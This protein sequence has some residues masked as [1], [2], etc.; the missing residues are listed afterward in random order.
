MTDLWHYAFVH[1]ALLAGAIV[2]LLAGVVG[3][4]VVTRNMAFAVH[5]S[6]EVGF[7]GAAGAL[8]IGLPPQVG[9][10]GAALATAVAIGVLGVRV[11][12]RDAAIGTTLAFGLGLGALFLSLYTRYANEAFSLLFGT[13]L[14]ISAQDVV[15]TAAVAAAS[16]ATLAVVYRPLRFASV[17]PEVAMARGVPVR[18][19]SIVF[20]VILAFAVAEAVQVVGVLLI[21]TL[22]ITPAAAAERLTP[23]PGW[24]TAWSAGIA[25]AATLGG[26]VS[27]LYRP[28]PVSFFVATYSFAA[29]LLARWLGPRLEARRRSRQAGSA[30]TAEG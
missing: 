27:A 19:L 20:L 28:W 15:L 23:S 3:P 12:E 22:L 2:A 5:A 11:R 30:G 21:L 26:I 13:I 10:L 18:G 4:F 14:G 7:T 29:Y 25:L 8:L 9:L 16:L 24:A 6:A 17:D 1:N